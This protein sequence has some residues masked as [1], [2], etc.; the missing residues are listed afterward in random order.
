MT[1]VDEKLWNRYKP[2]FAQSRPATE[3]PTPGTLRVMFG[4]WPP[5][6]VKK[7]GM[8][9]LKKNVNIFQTLYFNSLPKL[10]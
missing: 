4:K 10:F 5:W 8:F 7:I 2:N 9:K 1:T 3:N 6:E